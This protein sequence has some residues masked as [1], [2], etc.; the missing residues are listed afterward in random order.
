MNDIKPQ[1]DTATA[2]KVKKVNLRKVTVL[3]V[4]PNEFSRT[5]IRSIC[6]NLH[7]GTILIAANTNE[8]FDLLR[9]N[10]VQLIVCDWELKPLMSTE[11][12]KQLRIS[13]DIANNAVPVIILTSCGSPEAIVAARDA[14]V[15]DYLTR[16]IVMRRLLN[17][18]VSALCMPRVYVRSAAYTGPCRRR[19]RMLFYGPE[20]R[21]GW[22]AKTSA[23]DA[24][25]PPPTTVDKNAVLLGEDKDVEAGDGASLEEMEKAG[26][27]AI[28]EE[29]D[30]YSKVRL[31]DIAEI[32]E[33]VRQLK[34]P[35][36]PMQEVLL[37]MK[38][39]AQD[40]KGMG[41][42]F[43]YPLL[44]R[45]GDLLC[46]F[47][48]KSDPESFRVLAKLQVVETH[49]IIMKMIVDSNMHDEKDELAQELIGEL[50]VMVDK[51]TKT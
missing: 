29:A 12:V 25:V 5:F 48:D 51:F 50:V 30:N 26:E 10:Q 33:L 14:G 23:A 40:V 2:Q 47:L 3:I 44:T 19:R 28:A 6:R 46:G 45:V 38:T 17:S 11:F 49:A 7:F 15:D 41:N 43:G 1:E 31:D 42:T 27:A 20:R 22:P 8:A 34:Q 39:K 13:K 16:P 35:S 37:R 32:F 24:A 4:D 36:A 18:F 21:A 9:K